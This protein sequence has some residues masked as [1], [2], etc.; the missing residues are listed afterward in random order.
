MQGNPRER[1]FSTTFSM[2]ESVSRIDSSVNSTH[3]RQ[4]SETQET[5]IPLSLEEDKV[6]EQDNNQPM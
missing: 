1:E 3:F 5:M 2:Q 4:A 6:Q